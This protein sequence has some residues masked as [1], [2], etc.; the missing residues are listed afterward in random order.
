MTAHA[1]K[2]ILATINNSVENQSLFKEAL[3]L[4]SAMRARVVVVSVTP[5]YEGNTNRFFLN[6]AEQE[7]NKNLLEMLS[8][9]EEYATS[10]GLSLETIHRT[11]K[12]DEQICSVAYDIK[13]DVILLGCV[14]RMQMER[15]M[16]GRTTA[17]VVANSPCDVLLIPLETELRFDRILT[18]ISGSEASEE[19]GLRTIEIAKSYGSEVH[20]L[21]VTSIPTD[22]YLRYGVSR[23]AEQKGWKI[24]KNYIVSASE[25]DVAVIASTRGNNIEECL[26]EYIKE[27]NIHLLIIGSQ[28]NTFSLDMFFGSVL[29]RIV[30]TTPCPVLVA[31]KQINYSRGHR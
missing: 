4:A 18:G 2:T 31:K 17:E 7:F 25:Q 1:A 16:L 6:N 19:A 9:A 20:A 5:E 21:Y 28:T 27:K 26:T 15:I 11:G 13:A 14:K 22:R 29:E 30:S 8:E 24:L 23:E 10:L 12:P 3:A